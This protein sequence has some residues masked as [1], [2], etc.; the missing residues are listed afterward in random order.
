MRQSDDA[1]TVKIVTKLLKSPEEGGE[2]RVSGVAEPHVKARF[3]AADAPDER[4][5]AGSAAGRECD[6]ANFGR[7]LTC[8]VIEAE[9]LLRA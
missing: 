1:K 3:R 8:V 2:V 6:Q 5:E 7:S 9:G 4:V